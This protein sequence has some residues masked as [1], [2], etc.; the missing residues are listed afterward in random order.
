MLSIGQ[1]IA[2]KDGICS[3][4]F[5]RTESCKT[6]GQCKHGQEMPVIELEGDY[7][8][9]DYVSIYM[10][11]N[12]FLKATAFAYVL[13]LLG[14]LL[15]LFIGARLLPNPG[16]LQSILC[17]ALGLGLVMLYLRLSEKLR[18]GKP[19][20]EPYIR[21]KINPDTLEKPLLSEICIIKKENKNG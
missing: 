12:Q 11:D 6:C 3:I 13:P 20:W 7:A 16:D 1:V 17:G 15:G 18:K 5:L 4:S 21:E 10:P 8:V 19:S 2:N 9:G 14:L